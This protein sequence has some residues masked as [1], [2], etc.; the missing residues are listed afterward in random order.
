MTICQTLSQSNNHYSDRWDSNVKT[1]LTIK[2]PKNSNNLFNEFNNFTSQQN[3]NTE[4]IITCKYYNIDEI[5]NP[6]N[7]NP[8]DAS[9]L[10]QINTCSLIKNAEEPE[11]FID[12]TKSYFDVIGV[13]KS[14]IKKN[15]SPINNM[16]LK[17]YSYETFPMDSL[18]GCTLLCIG[19]HFFFKSRSNLCVYK[20]EELDTACN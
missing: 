2:T 14:R 13:S 19:N 1:C 8:K 15:K 3:K 4:N 10:F 17:D 9:S 11:Y 6:N 18:T 5:Q 12:K 7:L 16:N 20:S